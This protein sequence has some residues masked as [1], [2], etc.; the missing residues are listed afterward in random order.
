MNLTE[1]SGALTPQTTAAVALGQQSYL[2]KNAV[3]DLLGVSKRTVEN[4]MARRC[5]AYVRLSPRAIRFKR[6]DV[7]AAMDALRIGGGL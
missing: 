7:E 4:L 3:A 1:S 5:L 6:A 2:D